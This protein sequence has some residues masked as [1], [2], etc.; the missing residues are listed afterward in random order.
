MSELTREAILA[1]ED[2]KMEVVPVPEWGGEVRLRV[3]SGTELDAYEKSLVKI[4]V[5]GNKIEQQPDQT[6]ARCKLLARCICD[7]QG[8]LLFSAADIE[9]LGRKSKDAL[10]RLHSAAIK[11]NGLNRSLEDREKNS[12][13]DPEDSSGT[14]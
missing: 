4:S 1:A 8:K 14:V 7:S 6:N 11:L 2:L 3:M 12:Q 10:D 5:K 9:A 13:S